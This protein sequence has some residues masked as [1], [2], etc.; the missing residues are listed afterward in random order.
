[1]IQGRNLSNLRPR[2]PMWNKLL[3]DIAKNAEKKGTLPKPTP[4]LLRRMWPALVGDTIAWLSS[5]VRLQETTLYL[6]ARHP[7]LV[8]EWKSHPIPLLRRIREFSPWPIDKL[9]ISH[10]PN[11]G[12]PTEISEETIKKLHAQAT[13]K[14][15]EISDPEETS[16]SDEPISPRA[17]G[18]DAELQS[19][20]D[21]I[22]RHR[23]E[24]NDD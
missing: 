12:V 1:M 24:H 14:R 7:N 20:I 22:S 4:D 19:L 17:P 9:E 10:N 8:R 23:K 21:S 6:E 16:P 11:A 13:E 5:P 18:A 3:K 2:I 15:E